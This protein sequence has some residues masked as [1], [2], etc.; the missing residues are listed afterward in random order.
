[1][2]NE[3]ENIDE[4]IIRDWVAMKK[5]QHPRYWAKMKDRLEIVI[6]RKRRI[7]R[8]S[9]A[10][11]FMLPIVAF[12][13]YLLQDN[14]HHSLPPT[15]RTLAKVL[16]GDRKAILYTSD[17]SSLVLSGDTLSLTEVNGTRILSRKNEGIVYTPRSADDKIEIYN[18][19][20]V[21]P[22]G[23]YSITL[24][25]GT[26]VWL[27]SSSSLKYPVF[28]SDT[29]RKVQLEGEAYFV[30]S[31]NK[32]KPF[33]VE[34]KDYS[35]RV[36]GTAFN[37]MDYDDDNYSHTTLARGK[38]EILH[39]NT[40]RIL[41]PGEQALLKDGKM[42]IKKVDPRYYT[43]WMNERFYFDSESLEN[44]M[45][46]LSRWY[47]VQVTFKDEEAKQYHFEG[48]VPKYSSIKEVCNIIE[49][50]THVRFELEKNNIIVKI[51][52]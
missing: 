11:I 50:T 6:R 41:N 17:G 39:E 35:I 44:I 13:L 16:P 47:D 38:I 33:I 30:V 14:P 48:S 28:F 51:K 34:T 31:E 5:L 1:M 46:K 36:L 24:S 2:P 18:T 22:K 10:A 19:V 49:L 4:K 45:K 26:Q 3:P 15:E 23:E 25:D 27:N 20:V 40:R 29:L 21:P 7:R 43:T 9:Y 52:E 12:G 42:L 8:M 37:V 32:E